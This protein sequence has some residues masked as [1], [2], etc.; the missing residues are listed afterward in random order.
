[1]IRMIELNS[2]TRRMKRSAASPYRP[3]RRI[4]LAQVFE[5]GRS[6][7]SPPGTDLKPLQIEAA[8]HET[9]FANLANLLPKDRSKLY[10]FVA[11]LL[12]VIQLILSVRTSSFPTITPEQVEETIER[13]LDLS[14]HHPPPLLPP[15]PPTHP[16]PP[17]GEN[18]MPALIAQ[19]EYLRI[20]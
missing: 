11:V 4:T 10:A 9:P 2:Q 3:Q 13:V 1:M 5:Y 8:V 7:A 17:S 6:P 12:T 19:G 15:A 16:Q 14:E 18:E 20:R